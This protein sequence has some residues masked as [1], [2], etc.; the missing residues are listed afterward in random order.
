MTKNDEG[1]SGARQNLGTLAGVLAALLF[2]LASGATSYLTLSSVRTETDQVTST[3]EVITGL[4]D[5]LSAMQDAETGQRGFLLTGNPSYLE[6]YRDAQARSDA[7][8]QNLDR[9]TRDDPAQQSSLQALRPQVAT[10]F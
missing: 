8:L 2:F 4:G 5:L 1:A 10:K 9:L 6:P 3:H 7:I